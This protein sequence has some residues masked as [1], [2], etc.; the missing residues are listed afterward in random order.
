MKFFILAL[1]IL[2]VAITLNDAAG[3]AADNCQKILCKAPCRV[4]R[5]SNNC[6]VQMGIVSLYAQH[7]ADLSILMIQIAHTLVPAC[8]KSSI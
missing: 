6:P 4:I 3:A 1:V 2:G 5:N 7:L 8:S